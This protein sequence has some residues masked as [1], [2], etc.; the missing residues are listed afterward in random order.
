M[1]IYFVTVFLWICGSLAAPNEET[2]EGHGHSVPVRVVSATL[3]DTEA[4]GP[5]SSI[6][7]SVPLPQP[8][9]L[10]PNGFVMSDEA[11]KEAKKAACCL[12]IW[13][14]CICAVGCFKWVTPCL[15]WDD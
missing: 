13:L 5:S 6:I 9:A 14:P 2:L 4:R 10:S 1:F 15:G 12:C 7:S 8:E 3:S 11:K